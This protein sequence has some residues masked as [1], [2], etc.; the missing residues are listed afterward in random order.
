MAAPPLVILRGEGLPIK[1]AT[2]VNMALTITFLALLST[3]LAVQRPKNVLFLPVDDL[4]P[5]LFEAYN[6]QYMH[7]PNLD[8]LARESFVF[9]RAYCQHA[10]CI[11]SRN[12]FMTGRR[13]DTTQ[14]WSGI[15][16]HDFRQTGPNWITLPQ[17]FK[18]NGFTTLGGGKTFHPGSPPRLG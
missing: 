15:G 9:Q 3:V 17:H 7:T 4:R 1:V 10:V 14:V 5:E 6:Q 18:E 2:L 8:K 12:S 16:N 11:P 13:P